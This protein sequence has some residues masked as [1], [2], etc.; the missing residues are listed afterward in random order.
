[1]DIFLVYLGK[2]STM[3]ILTTKIRHKHSG[4]NLSDL[5]LS[6]I[7]KGASSN[8]IT[9]VILGGKKF[10]SREPVSSYDFVLAS[11]KGITKQSIINLADLMNVPMKDIAVLLNVS[12]KT[13]GRKRPT[14]ILDSLVSSL[15]IE[16]AN[17]IAKGLSVFEDPDKVNR[18]LQKENKALNG[19]KP[20]D[21]LN[22]P[23]GIKMVNKVLN[24]IEEGIYT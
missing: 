24:R 5:V 18:W 2:M 20:F 19:K 22:T 10:M 11:N 9:W 14:D 16:I 3:V 7:R 15:S 12:Y 4:E 6:Y 17:T 1:M 23:T 8:L 21:L 13:L